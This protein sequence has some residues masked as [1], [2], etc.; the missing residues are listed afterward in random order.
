MTASLAILQIVRFRE[1]QVNTRPEWL[2]ITYAVLVTTGLALGLACLGA[3]L[4]GTLSS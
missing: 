3:G 2:D 4:L 1:G